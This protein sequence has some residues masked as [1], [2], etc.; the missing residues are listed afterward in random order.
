MNLEDA[1]QGSSLF[2]ER[3]ITVSNLEI[4]CAG[5]PEGGGVSGRS[6]VVGAVDR[7]V[8]VSGCHTPARAGPVVHHRLDALLWICLAC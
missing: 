5:P 6:I 1:P 3:R 7:A 4:S 8:P 2:G